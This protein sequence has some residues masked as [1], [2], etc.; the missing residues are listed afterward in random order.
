MADWLLLV[1]LAGLLVPASATGTWIMRRF[2]LAHGVL[3]I[4]N[5]RSAHTR[6]TPTSGGAAITM[7]FLLALGSLA[8]ADI[9]PR[10]PATAIGGGVAMLAAVG[11]I[12][13][14][15][16]VSPV[17]RFVVHAAAAGWAL[18]WL[19]PP[20]TVTP[21]A[22]GAWVGGIVAWLSIIWAIN[23]YNFMDGI[24][25]LAGG[26]AV[27][28][29]AS[30]TALF[31][32]TGGKALAPVALSL[33]AATA[34]FLVWNW[35]PAKIFM[36]DVG[37]GAVGYAFAVLAVAGE[38]SGSVPLLTVWLLLGTLVVDATVT[39]LRRILAREPF[40]EAHRSH[41]YQR[42][43]E[44][45]CNHRQVTLVMLGAALLLSAVAAVT[46]AFPDALLASVL[47]VTVALILAQNAVIA[48]AD[49][50]R[51]RATGSP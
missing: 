32:G 41:A 9:V 42:A 27:V 37:S 24:D 46:V 48:A 18:A 36:G 33:A 15:R 39:L 26:T 4:P 1:L 13:D 22:T 47:T 14:L 29:G 45:G 34:G 44:L 10:G 23:L 19:G 30:L 51:E 12:D 5:A 43:L 7:V 11:F 49:R 21:L 31:L 40:Y 17:V 28:A 38:R 8:T 3:D 20:L 35:P 2:G 50:R 25:G 6:P 16:G